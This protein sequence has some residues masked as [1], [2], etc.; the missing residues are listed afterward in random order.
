MEIGLIF[1]IYHILDLMA[2]DVDGI[3][4]YSMNKSDFISKLMDNIGYVA[5]GFFK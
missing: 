5:S 1:T 4:I 3:N 2:N